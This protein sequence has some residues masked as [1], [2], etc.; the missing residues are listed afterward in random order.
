MNWDDAR[1]FLAVHRNGTLRAAARAIGLDQAT[2]GRRISALEQ[3]LGTTLFLRT[4]GGFVPTEAARGMIGPAELMERSA[5]ELMRVAS[6]KDDRFAGLVRVATT[7]TLAIELVIPAIARLARSHP[8][9][10]VSLSASTEVVNLVRRDADI[11]IRTVDPE[12]PDLVARRIAQW[13]MGL[14]ASTDYLARCGQPELSRGFEGHNLVVYEPHLKRGPALTLGGEPIAS[15]KVV[16][17]AASSLMVRSMIKDGMG[18]GE[19]A[20]PIAKRDGLVRIWPDRVRSQSY[21]IWMVTHRDL[22]RTARVRATI[23]HIVEE[24]ARLLQD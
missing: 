22:H 13:P 15:G 11:A 12:N 5:D 7:D 20:I 21:D 8:E 24:F 10:T 9:I 19:V 18:L 2:V 17:A 3:N 4:S 1:I 14:F 16:A 23:D 6:G